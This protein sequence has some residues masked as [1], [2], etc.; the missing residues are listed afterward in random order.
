MKARQSLV[1]KL[2]EKDEFGNQA[3]TKPY[4]DLTT[5]ELGR[6]SELVSIRLHLFN[7]NYPEFMPQAVKAVMEHPNLSKVDYDKLNTFSR[8][9]ELDW[10]GDRSLKNK[11][12]FLATNPVYLGTRDQTNFRGYGD[13]G[14]FE[15]TSLLRR[16]CVPFVENLA[17]KMVKNSK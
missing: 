6:I 13:I 16:A 11:K 9:F 15:V 2:L 5:N 17:T 8:M 3:V 7:G 10:R 14:N 12:E 4:E 1:G